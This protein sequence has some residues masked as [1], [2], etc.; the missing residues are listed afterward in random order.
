MTPI[1]A[2]VLG[3]ELRALQDDIDGGGTNEVAFGSH[4]VTA[5]EATA[6]LVNITTGLGDL[7]LAD[8]AVTVF[9]AGTNVTSDA[10]ITEPSAGVLRIADGSTYNTTAG[11]IINWM[12]H[13]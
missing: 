9:R 6:N 1:A 8:C 13:E 11:D 12:A 10:V 2:T 4:T 5:G 3:V 7:T